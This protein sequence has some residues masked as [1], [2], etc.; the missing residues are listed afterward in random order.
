MENRT[1]EK[2]GNGTDQF[3]HL[4]HEM[5]RAKELVNDFVE[6]GKRK[7]QRMVKRGVVAAEDYVEDTTYYIK[8]HPWQSVGMAAGVGAGTGLLL[9]WMFSRVCATNGKFQAVEH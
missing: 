3:A 2:V 5:S 9:G 8:R 6:D 4:T 1:A 7:A